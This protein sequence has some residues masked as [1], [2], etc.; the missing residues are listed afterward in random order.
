MVGKVNK[1][2]LVCGRPGLD[3]K[4]SADM[5]SKYIYHRNLRRTKDSIV[6]NFHSI[7]LHAGWSLTGVDNAQPGQSGNSRIF[8]IVM[9]DHM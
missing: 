9:P 6:N 4:L 1:S 7:S 5:L 2:R 8:I 3:C